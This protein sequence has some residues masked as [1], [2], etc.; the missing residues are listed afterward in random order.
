[1]NR[2][3]HCSTFPQLIVNFLDKL[4]SRVVGS[5]KCPPIRFLPLYFKRDISSEPLQ[6]FVQRSMF[7]PHLNHNDPL[8]SAQLHIFL[9]KTFSS[10]DVYN[11]TYLW[12]TAYFVSGFIT[13]SFAGSFSPAEPVHV[14]GALI[15]SKYAFSLSDSFSSL[16]LQVEPVCYDFHVCTFRSTFALEL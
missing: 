10:P 13:A 9:P 12:L 3:C 16:W 14:P 6:K 2:F 4:K 8:M 7:F 11:P 5:S 15:S 1:M